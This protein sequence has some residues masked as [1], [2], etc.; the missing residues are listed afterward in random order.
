MDNWHVDPN[1]YHLESCRRCMDHAGRP[2][3]RDHNGQPCPVCNGTRKVA[4][5]APAPKPGRSED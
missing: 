4:P 5:N 3:G 2:T 1:Q